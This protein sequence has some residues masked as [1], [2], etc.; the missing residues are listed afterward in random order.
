MRVPCQHYVDAA[1]ALGHLA[2]DIEAVVRKQH[3]EVGAR[4]LGL[5]DLFLHVGFAEAE[6]PVRDHPARVGDGRERQRLADHGDLDAAALE[7]LLRRKHRLLEFRLAY[8][9]AEE[10]EAELRHQL[11]DAGFAEREFPM[12]RHGIGLQ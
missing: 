5:V 9:L 6:R 8:V 1:H 7:H 3:D 10:G 11:L 2:V 4:R 12:C